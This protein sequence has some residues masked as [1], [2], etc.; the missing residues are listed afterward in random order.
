MKCNYPYTGPNCTITY[1]DYL[2]ENN[3][4]NS[5]LNVQYFYL[6]GSS[7]TFFASLYLLCM[8]YKKKESYLQKVTYASCFCVSIL[9]IVRG[10]DPESYGNIIPKIINQLCWDIST[11]LL[12]TV[13]FNYLFYMIKSFDIYNKKPLAKI[14]LPRLAKKY[15]FKIC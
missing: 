7:I 3:R 14:N 15:F 5:Y 8:S 1:L 13:L 10:I 9:F 12:Y 11:S 6:I 2:K 4:Y